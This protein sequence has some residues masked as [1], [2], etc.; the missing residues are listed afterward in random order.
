MACLV[1]DN[2][3][4]SYTIPARGPWPSLTFRYRRALYQALNEYK[5]VARD[6]GAKMTQDVAKFIEKHLVSWDLH[7]PNKQPLPGT[8]EWIAKL[9]AP[10]IDELYTAVTGYSVQDQE[11]DLKNSTPASA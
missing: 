3:T 7:G 8:A 11:S 10:Y 2:Y 4:L 1:D 6:T 9:P 5:I